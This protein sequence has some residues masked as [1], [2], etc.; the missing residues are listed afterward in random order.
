[1]DNNGVFIWGGEADAYYERNAAALAA[2]DPET[3][4]VYQLME[5]ARLDDVRTI[6]DMGCASGERLS[7]LTKRLNCDGIGI[8]MSRDAIATARHRDPDTRWMIEPVEGSEQF[9]DVDVIIAS[10]VLH[11]LRR[12]ALLHVVHRIDFLLQQSLGEK[13]LVINDFYPERP[14]TNLYHHRPKERVYTFKRRYAD[15][16]LET[17]L[18]SVLAHREYPYH[19]TTEKAAVS[20]LRRDLS[21]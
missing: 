19:G 9:A 13:Y 1:V 2:Y 7:A 21:C 15:I 16:F 14:V 5:S 11:W 8:D 10:M 6:L 4:P 3:D 18:Y 20:I 12:D 17:G